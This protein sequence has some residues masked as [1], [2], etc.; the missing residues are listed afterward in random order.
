MLRL[1]FQSQVSLGEGIMTGAIMVGVWRG[2][3]AG[4]WKGQVLLDYSKQLIFVGTHW[5]AI[6]TTLVTSEAIATNDPVI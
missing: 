6:R 5:N 2:Q 3:K 1:E 4:N